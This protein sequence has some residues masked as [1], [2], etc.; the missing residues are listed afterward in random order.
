MGKPLIIIIMGVAGSGKSLVGLKLAR[1]LG[2]TFREGDEFHPAANI[3]KMSA[4]IPLDDAD[5][6]PYLLAVR[7]EI[8]SCLD[9]RRSAVV[10]CSALKESHREMLAVDPARV[11][12]VHLTGDPALI[13]DRLAGRHG[14]FMKPE[15]LASQLAALEPPADALTLDIAEEPDQLVARI[16]TAFAL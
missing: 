7:A 3:A 14:H 16:R 6:V 10:A 2:W 12:F 13:R 11:K 15:M 9:E 5:R 1:A 4:G 8:E